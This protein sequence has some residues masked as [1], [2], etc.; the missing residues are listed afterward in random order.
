MVSSFSNSKMEKMERKWKKNGT[1]I[2]K[3]G[4]EM[5]KN[6]TKWNKMEKN[7]TEM[8]QKWKKWKC[9]RT[10]HP[11]PLILRKNLKLKRIIRGTG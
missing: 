8:E 7:G 3:N 2:E 6:G 5:E 4:T 9:L 10:T 11:V 1:E